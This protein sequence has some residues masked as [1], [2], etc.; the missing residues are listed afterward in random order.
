MNIIKACY[1]IDPSNGRYVKSYGFLS[2]AKNIGKNI[3][4][5]YSQKLVDSA[6]TSATDA[7]HTTSKIAIQ[8]TAEATGDLIGNKIAE[9]IISVSKKSPKV[10]DSKELSSNEAINEIAKERYVSPQERQ[11]IID[12]L[13]LT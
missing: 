10:F 4:S 11:Q 1:S 9:K 3:S 8:K 7:I 6:K 2:F 5:K 12:E 13:R